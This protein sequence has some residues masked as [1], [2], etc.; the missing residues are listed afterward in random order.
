MHTSLV[1]GSWLLTIPLP[2]GNETALH[3]CHH[4]KR[5]VLQRPSGQE[6][7]IIFQAPGAGLRSAVLFV[8]EVDV[9]SKGHLSQMCKQMDANPNTS[10]GDL[11]KT[12][13][14]Y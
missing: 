10:L 3:T 6:L 11:Q 4:E 2:Q 14:S 9:F 1:A 12:S 5:F 7:K 8:E 13:F